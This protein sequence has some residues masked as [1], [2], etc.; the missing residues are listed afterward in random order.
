MCHCQIQCNFGGI[1]DLCKLRKKIF[2][3][4]DTQI[5]HFILDKILKLLTYYTPF[6]HRSLQSY[7]IS[8]TVWFFWPTLWV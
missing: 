3:C 1:D 5:M 2:N 8:K 6:R 7:V 4:T